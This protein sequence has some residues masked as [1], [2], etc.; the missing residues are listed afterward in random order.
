MLAHGDDEKSAASKYTSQGMTAYSAGDY[1]LAIESFKNAFSLR[2]DYSALAYNISCCYA[3]LGEMD[4][5]IVW[6][7]KTFELGSYLFLEDE[8]LSSLHADPRYQNLVLKAEQKIEELKDRDWNP[9]VE[10]SDQYCDDKPCPVVIGLHGFG[11]SPVDFAKSLGSAVLEAGYV[12]CCPYGPYI[13][14]TTAF[15]WGDCKDAQKRILES[16]QYLADEYNIDDKRVILLGFSEG[17]G[18]AFCVGFKHPEIFAGI[19]SVAGFY[20]EDL[21]EHFQDESLK[22][23]PTYMMIGEN[24]YGAESN[25]VAE[26]L[27][28]ANGLIAKLVVYEGMGHAFPPN[29]VDEV[30]QALQWV[31]AAE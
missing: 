1:P 9:V 4:S 16:V 29:G 17:G 28:K 25:R 13:G 3:L 7:E 18:I 22:N 27:M 30:K 21:N 19:I 23:M 24:D 26:Q 2:P 10:L 20:D 5:A 31:E 12:F 15:G 11:T 8:D 6:L 14:G